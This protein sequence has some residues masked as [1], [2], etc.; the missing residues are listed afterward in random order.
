MT[1]VNL[2]A[3]IKWFEDHPY[4]DIY[5]PTL[6]VSATTFVQESCVSFISISRIA[7]H[8]ALVETCVKF[9]YGDDKVIVCCIHLFKNYLFNIPHFKNKGI[10][11]FK[12]NKQNK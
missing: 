10:T 5:I 12:I 4:K 3:H 9:D 11:L 2:L 1:N 6:F 8:C 7:G